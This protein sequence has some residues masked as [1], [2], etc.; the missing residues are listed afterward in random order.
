MSKTDK[1][2]GHTV[3][4]LLNED[5]DWLAHFVE[6]PN[7]SAF[8]NTPEQATQELTVAWEGIKESYRKHGESM[9]EA[10]KH[11]ISLH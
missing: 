11:N 10:P 7:V 3:N 6:L 5:G 4:L 9:L 8:G 1:F 2:D